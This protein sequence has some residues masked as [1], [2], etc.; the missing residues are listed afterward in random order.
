VRRGEALLFLAAVLLAGLAGGLY[1]RPPFDDEIHT[2]LAIEELGVWRIIVTGF[3]GGDIH[4]PLSTALFAA[5]SAFGLGPPA[6]RVVAMLFS[7]LAFLAVLDVVLRNTQDADSNLMLRR[8]RSGRLEAWATGTEGAAHPSRRARWVLLRVRSEPFETALRNGRLATIVL[9]AACP[10]LFGVGDSLRWY[11]LFALLTALFL[12]RV[13]LDGGPSV[14]AGVL[15]GLAGMTSFLAVVPAAAF[16]LHRYVLN[17]RFAVREDGAFLVIVAVMAVPSA[18]ALLRV[19]E[20]IP[21]LRDAGPVG[22]LLSLGYGF[23]AGGRL[24]PSWVA[25]V[26]PYGVVMAGA[27][28]LIA[29]RW[30]QAPD[31]AIVALLM[32]A[33]A[34]IALLAIGNSQP[35]SLLFVAPWLCA[36]LALAPAALGRLEPVGRW[37]VLM[38]AVVPTLFVL[39]TLRG[40]EHPFKRNL[41][42]PY[43]AAIDWTLE[44]VPAGAV[45]YVSEPVLEYTLRERGLCVI[46]RTRVDKGCEPAGRPV[47]V[48][49]DQTFGRIDYLVEGA[50][51]A[52]AGRTSIAA[53]TFGI[54]RDA[55]LKNRLTGANLTHW[56]VRIEVWRH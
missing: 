54:D 28:W 21:G 4:P 10:L 53:Q 12:R 35:R 55:G 25:A 19:S 31:L 44:R 46:G 45:V 18:W 9:F 49:R 29:R 20:A 39:L 3:D 40:T 24:G 15:L 27:I 38:A 1:L 6:L 42:I 56:I 30:R 22:S 48:V 47:V 52:T 43:D 26:A 7:A 33:L 51:R 37:L 2:L 14:G 50:A 32:A 36:L 16:G 11:P 17:R 23:F 34:A 8:P 5:M 41:V 13:L